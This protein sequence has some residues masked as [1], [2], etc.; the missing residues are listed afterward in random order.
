M[1][2]FHAITCVLAM[3]IN[4]CFAH[5]ATEKTPHSQKEYEVLRRD[6]VDSTS[7][8]TIPL[9]ESEVED[10]LQINKNERKTIFSIPSS[11]L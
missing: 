9:D 10:E 4:A 8:L 3:G 7:T 2:N 6:Q 5:A 11:H 1:K